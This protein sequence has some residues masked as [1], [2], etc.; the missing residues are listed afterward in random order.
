MGA[1]LLGVGRGPQGFRLGERLL[2]QRAAQHLLGARTLAPGGHV[3]GPSRARSRSFICAAWSVAHP[4]KRGKSGSTGLAGGDHL[5][6]SMQVDGVQINP[7]EWWDEHWI[8]DHVQKRL[9]AK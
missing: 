8:K 4:A 1:G 5:H 7:V 6:F 3:V 2:A 9:G